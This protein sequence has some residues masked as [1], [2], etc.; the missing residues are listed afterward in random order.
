MKVVDDRKPVTKELLKA[1]VPYTEQNVKLAFK[2]GL[3]FKDLEKIT[4]TNRN[5]LAATLSRA[6]RRGWVI[7]KNGVPCL[8]E[9]GRLRIKEVGPADLLNGWLLVV[10]DIPEQRRIDRYSFR[11]R[12]KELGFA[13]LQKSTWYS[14][15][16]HLDELKTAISELKIGRYVCVFLAAETYAPQLRK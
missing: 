1:L 6:K 13:M 14:N 15:E 2:P 11:Q 4:K 10:F 8:S 12:L 16:D 3:F 9:K 7:E 5:C